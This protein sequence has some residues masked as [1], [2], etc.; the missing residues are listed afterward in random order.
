MRYNLR[1]VSEDTRQFRI[2]EMPE[3]LSADEVRMDLQQERDE[4][5]IQRGIEDYW[6][7]RNLA[8]RNSTQWAA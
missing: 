4:R 6:A 3:D 1:E 8:G 7:G 2:V 5:E